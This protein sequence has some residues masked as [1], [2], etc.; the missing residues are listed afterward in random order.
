MKRT[1]SLLLALLLLLSCAAALSACRKKKGDAVEPAEKAEWA[2]YGLVYN[3]ESNSFLRTAVRELTDALG[4]R[5]GQNP[6]CEETK[7]GSG[8][9][10]DEFEIVIGA[11]DR[12]ATETGKSRVGENGW[13]IIPTGKKIIIYGSNP[14]F[15]VV[16]LQTFMNTYLP[17]GGTEKAP[18]NLHEDIHA[19]APVVV[20]ASGQSLIFD[21]RLDDTLGPTTDNPFIPAE[22]AE[23][24]DYPVIAARQL[25]KT[26]GTLCGISESGITL[27]K[28]SGA[29]RDYEIAV[30]ITNRPVT[31]SLLAELGNV[32]RYGFLV[33]DGKIAVAGFKRRHAPAGGG[34]FHKLPAKPD[35]ARR[36]ADAARRTFNSQRKSER[37]V[38]DR[39]SSAS[40]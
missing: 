11:T 23:G 32:N 10:N 21:K 30:G 22:N 5:T 17:A 31:Q 15:T 34:T 36:G 7:G 1:I 28:D 29:V 16:A 24:C 26:I 40:I 39:F 8:V 4:D 38:G 9:E 19:N 25:R 33:R 35:G 18:V 2:D 27:R 14:L 6:P 20:I 13:C 3:A 12:T 37:Q